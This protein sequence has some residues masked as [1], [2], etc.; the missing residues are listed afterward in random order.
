MGRR[1]IVPIRTADLWLVSNIPALASA[2]Y[3][4]R[5]YR[6]I[7]FRDVPSTPDPHLNRPLIGIRTLRRAGLR[8]EMD[9]AQDTIS[10]WTPDFTAPSP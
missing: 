2:P 4:L 6:G 10:V 7:P 8:V 1:E 9:F 3:C 5:L